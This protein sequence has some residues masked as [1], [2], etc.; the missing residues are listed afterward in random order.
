VCKEGLC[1]QRGV[2][3]DASDI[4]LLIPVTV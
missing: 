4:E 3:S 1:L 2:D